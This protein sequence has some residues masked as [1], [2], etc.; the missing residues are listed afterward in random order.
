MTPSL[1][2]QIFGAE[3]AIADDAARPLPERAKAL[4]QIA[5]EMGVEANPD[6]AALLAEYEQTKAAFAA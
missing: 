5:D 4:R 1:E 3:Y 2:I 6:D